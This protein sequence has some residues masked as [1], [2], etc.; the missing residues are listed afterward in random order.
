MSAHNGIVLYNIL[1]I[2]HSFLLDFYSYCQGDRSADRA[3]MIRGRP[4]QTHLEPQTEVIA[5]ATLA[6]SLAVREPAVL[7]ARL[8]AAR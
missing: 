4:S 1:E 5:G 7:R 3:H 8:A 2:Q 6:T